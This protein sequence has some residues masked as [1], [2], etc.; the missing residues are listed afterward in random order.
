MEIRRNLPTNIRIKSLRKNLE[1]KPSQEQLAEM[2]DISVKTYAGYENG[3]T[4]IPTNILIKLARI[5]D[6]S[7]DHMLG[8]SDYTNIDNE[9]MSVALGLSDKSINTLKQYKKADSDAYNEIKASI[10]KHKQPITHYCFIMPIINFWLSSSRLQK[11]MERFF[12]MSADKY[13]VPIYDNGDSLKLFPS[14]NDKEKDF[15]Y[16]GCNPDNPAD[17]ISIQIDEDFRKEISRKLLYNSL[18]DI[19]ADY[20]KSKQIASRD[21]EKS[22][23]KKKSHK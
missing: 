22:V 5:F 9:Y 21:F 6:V 8:N 11:F 10:K 19:S 15:L 23:R 12:N 2:L 20:Q 4:A 13:Q 16:L 17:N 18:N 7:I 3:H 14:Y 1:N